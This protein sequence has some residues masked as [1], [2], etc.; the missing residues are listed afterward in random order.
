M[1]QESRCQMFLKLSIIVIAIVTIFSLIMISISDTFSIYM[2]DDFVD[3]NIYLKS[4]KERSK[5]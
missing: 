2:S 4:L 5:V 3:N 1:N